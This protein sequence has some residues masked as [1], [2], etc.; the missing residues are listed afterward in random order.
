VTGIRHDAYAEQHRIKIEE[1]KPPV[2]RDLV[3]HR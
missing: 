1:E 3:A 2:Q